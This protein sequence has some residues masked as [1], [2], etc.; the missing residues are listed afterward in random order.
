MKSRIESPCSVYLQ[1]AS[2][3]VETIGDKKHE[4]ETGQDAHRVINVSSEKI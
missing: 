4:N 1:G 3:K 2:G